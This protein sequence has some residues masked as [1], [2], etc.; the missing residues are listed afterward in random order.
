MLLFLTLLLAVFLGCAGFFACS[1]ISLFSLSPMR[2]KAFKQEKDPRKLLV[3]QLLDAPRDLLVTVIIVN[4]ILGILVQNVASSM[5][6]DFSGWALNV[7]VPLALTLVFG[8][9]VPK[10]IGLAHNEKISYRVAPFLYFAQRILS[11]IR[12][13]FISITTRLSQVMFF[14]L[15]KE[16]EISGEELQH[17]LK[18][19]RVSGVLHEDEAELIRGYLQLQEAQAQDLRR[20]R[21]EILYFQLQDPLSRLVHL[22]VDQKC[23]RIPVCKGGLDEVMGII[24][25]QTFFLH[26]DK[27]RS[28]EDLKA[29]LDPPFFVPESVSALAL[30]QQM[31]KRQ[32]SLAMVVDEYGMVSGLIALEDL[33]E[34]VIGEIADARDQKQQYTR[35]GEDVMIASGKLELAEFEEVFSVTLSNE[36]HRVTL[37]GWLTDQ[38]G[39]IPK[40]GT[41]HTRDGFLFHILSAEPRR[42][43][44][45]YIRRLGLK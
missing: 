14:Y 20:P 11:P 30:L 4:V 26:R 3:A 12:S 23:S 21:E 6:G 10:S 8:E 33:V 44:R 29:Y 39:D 35:S 9:V 16:K 22:F 13:F 34:T 41:K 25:G 43:R 36:T 31:Y 18:A 5:F 24:S 2:V 32:E 1:E 45:I 7:G 40:T 28:V 19:S 15:R 37:G 42:I 38:L 17:A 27:I